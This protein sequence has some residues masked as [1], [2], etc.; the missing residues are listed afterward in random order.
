M[1]TPKQMEKLASQALRPAAHADPASDAALPDEYWEA[2]LKDRGA[3]PGWPFNKGGCPEQEV[4]RLALPAP[5]H[6]PAASSDLDFRR[7][8]TSR[9]LHRHG[10][11]LCLRTSFINSFL[12]AMN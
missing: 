2:L 12:A 6:P 11:C 7:P 3:A 10:M 1:P 9:D 5:I 4:G 8:S